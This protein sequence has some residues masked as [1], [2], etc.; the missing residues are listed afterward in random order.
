MRLPDSNRLALYIGSHFQ[1][2]HNLG[3]DVG[4]TYL[5]GMETATINKFTQLGP[6]ADNIIDATADNHAQLFGLQLVWAI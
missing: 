4:Y 2:R 6:T 5:F 3:L 1:L